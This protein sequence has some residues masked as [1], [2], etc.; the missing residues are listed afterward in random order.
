M[1]CCLESICIN[2]LFTNE[3]WFCLLI[4]DH[5]LLLCRLKMRH[6]SCLLV[7]PLQGHAIVF[8]RN[9]GK[10]LGAEHVEV[11]ANQSSRIRWIDN[12]VNK[13]ALCDYQWIGKALGVFRRVF[14]DILA[15]VQ[16]FDG[17]LGSHCI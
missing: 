14:L 2:H 16:N 17:A 6:Y 15:A 10:V 8:A 3:Q 4:V 7:S 13:A 11:V 12:I 5:E 1:L 9:V